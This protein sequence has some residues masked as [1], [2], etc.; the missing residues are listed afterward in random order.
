M[1]LSIS[2]VS[3]GLE[4]EPEHQSAL[5]LSGRPRDHDN[6]FHYGFNSISIFLFAFCMK[7][8]SYVQIIETMTSSNTGAPASVKPSNMTEQTAVRRPNCPKG[9]EPSRTVQRI[10]RFFVVFTVA[11]GKSV[12]YISTADLQQD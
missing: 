6:V 12:A 8:N 10:K 9:Q 3:Q 5:T 1:V 2:T 7:T 4:L 11:M